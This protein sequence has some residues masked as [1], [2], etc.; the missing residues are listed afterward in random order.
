MCCSGETLNPIQTLSS[1]I[2]S[3][4]YYFLIYDICISHSFLHDIRIPVENIEQLI[5]MLNSCAE[6]DEGR[7]KVKAALLLI[8]VVL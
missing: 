7:F 1:K 3:A 2:K 5:Q 8:V 4:Y 6:K